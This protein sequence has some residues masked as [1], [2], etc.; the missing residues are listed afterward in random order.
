MIK[1]WVLTFIAAILLVGCGGQP[2][3]MVGRI[4]DETGSP[5]PKAEVFTEPGTDLVL[6]NPKGLFVIRHRLNDLG[7]TEPIPPGVYTV[8]V[9]KFGFE[10]LGFELKIEGGANKVEDMVMKIL[11]PDIEETAPDPTADQEREA[12]EASVPI[13]GN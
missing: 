8:R 3:S 9:R 4:I 11:T 1:P 2:V 13:I 10:E 6:T 12:D 7:E 5:I